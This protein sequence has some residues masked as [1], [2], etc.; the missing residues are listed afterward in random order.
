MFIVYMFIILEPEVMVMNSPGSTCHHDSPPA[1]WPGFVRFFVLVEGPVLVGV[2]SGK[3][4]GL[5]MENGSFTLENGGLTNEKDCFTL[6]NSRLTMQNHGF[7][8]GKG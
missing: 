2:K 4:G 3:H 6:E 8:T 5:T 7:K 1:S